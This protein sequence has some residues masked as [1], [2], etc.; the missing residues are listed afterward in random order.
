MG[1]ILTTITIILCLVLPAN[2]AS[3]D[4]SGF[5]RVIDGDTFWIGETKVR[6]FNIDAPEPNQKCLDGNGLSYDCGGRAADA[7]SSLMLNHAVR[8]VGD[9]TDD[10][11]L[12]IGICFVDN[13]NLNK[14]MVQR[15]W[16]VVYRQKKY[17]EHYLASEKTAKKMGNGL[18]AG[19]FV[20]PWD[21]QPK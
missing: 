1:K 19:D 6:L 2:F 8:C 12:L 13:T 18:W 17:D 4:V 14:E 15:G 9:K 10:Q 5:A 20:M 21:W 3:A 16:A 11:G 7:L